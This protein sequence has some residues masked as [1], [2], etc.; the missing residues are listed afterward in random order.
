MPARP[1]ST[2][3][4]A[5]LRLA[6]VAV[7]AL[8]GAGLLCAA[9]LVPAPPAVLPLLVVVCIGSPMVAACELPGAIAGLR[10]GPGRVRARELRELERLRRELD[11]LPETQHPL[12]L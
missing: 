6:F 1:P 8:M 4:S 7:T 11:A 10:R 3:G 12:G 2:R 5:L 9:A